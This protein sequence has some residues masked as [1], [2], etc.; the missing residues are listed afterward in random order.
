M[1]QS[2][3]YGSVR[4]CCALTS[5]TFLQLFDKGGSIVIS[6]SQSLPFLEVQIIDIFTITVRV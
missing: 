2:M 3:L 4:F 6:T 1:Q 5:V